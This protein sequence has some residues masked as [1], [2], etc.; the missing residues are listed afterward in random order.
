MSALGEAT[1]LNSSSQDL[2][3]DL[4]TDLAPEPVAPPVNAK[5]QACKEAAFCGMFGAAG[6][7]LA[8]LLI[9]G[10]TYAVDN[11]A[12]YIPVAMLSGGIAGGIGA[13]VGVAAKAVFSNREGCRIARGLLGA[14]EATSAA[15]TACN[16]VSWGLPSVLAMPVW[17]QFAIGIPSLFVGGVACGYPNACAGSIITG[18]VTSLATGSIAGTLLGAA[19]GSAFTNTTP[20]GGAILGLT[21]LMAIGGYTFFPLMNKKGEA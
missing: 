17:K 12:E 11:E 13:S 18:G 16:V 6:G 4:D 19:F 10:L 5:V 7:T 20:S 14:F 3:W 9:S 2:E 21:G 15:F 1:L 8:G